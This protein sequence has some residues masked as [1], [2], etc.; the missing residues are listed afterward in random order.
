MINKVLLLICDGLGDRP[1]P[2]LGDKTPLEAAATPNLDALAAQSQCGL[3]C[4]LGR[5]VRPGSDV[6]HLAIMGYDPARDYPGRGPIEVA[7]LGIALEDG[8]I[9]LRGNFGNVDDAGIC[10]DRHCRHISDFRPYAAAVDGMEIDGVRFI[11]KPGTAH[12]AGVVLRG[13]GLSDAITDADPHKTDEHLH[14]VTPT[15][16]SPEARRTAEVLRKFFV[17]AAGILR[18]HPQNLELQKAGKTPA[19]FV[20]VR[21]AGR[22]RRLQPFRERWGLSAACV[23]GGGLY[24]GIGALL[25]MKVIDVPGATGKLDTD[26]DAKMRAAVAALEEHDFVFLH[27]KAA[28][29]QGEDGKWAEKKAFIERIDR[30]LAP[31]LTLPPTT[32][33]IA[34][35]DHST[36][37]ILK[38]HS[39]DPVPIIFRGE[40]VRVDGV[41]SYGERSC[42]AGDLG[43]MAGLDVMPHIMNLMGRL[44]LIGA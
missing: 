17:R 1:V 23:A 3:L 13:K 41:R 9:A 26:L 31:A 18:N 36:P 34:T 25:G 43:L 22:Y 5:G 20:L 7:G 10:R 29:T 39:A 19:N 32:L 4:A 33:F 8:D 21:G 37:C 15:D 42:A 6:S 38:A 14:E 44:P 27:F 28:D 24:K 11:V 30:A 40:S 2:Q 35:A 12:R 16:D